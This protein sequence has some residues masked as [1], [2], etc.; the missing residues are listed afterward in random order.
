MTKEELTKLA[1]EIMGGPVE[2]VHHPATDVQLEEWGRKC[3]P[4]FIVGFQL[5]VRTAGP[6]P[7]A[8]REC[9]RKNVLTFMPIAKMGIEA[10]LPEGYSVQVR[11]LKE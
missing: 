9:L 11:E 3:Y 8:A 4:E 10:P 7:E 2:T 5:V 1:D 6:I